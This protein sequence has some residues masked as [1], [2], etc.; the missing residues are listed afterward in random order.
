MH[1]STIP[2]LLE[3]K[4]ST[5]RTIH[6][7]LDN[8]DFAAFLHLTTLSLS[9]G[10]EA[11]SAVAIV[12]HFKLLSLKEFGM[13]VRVLPWAEAEQLPRALSLRNALQTL[14]HINI[15]CHNTIQEH[16]SDS[17]TAVRQFLCFKEL[18]MLRLSVHRAI[19]LDDDLL[20][21]AMTTWPHIHTLSL[22][23]LVQLP[24][25]FAGCSRRFVYVRSCK[26]CKY[27]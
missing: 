27:Q 10:I 5:P 25:H 6:Y 21:D 2:T 16:T 19:H 1:L 17:L 20:F 3:V 13:Y 8:L 12:Q 15:F 9:G 26:T 22:G 23:I 7:P 11:A 18:R 24:L 4:I 14:E